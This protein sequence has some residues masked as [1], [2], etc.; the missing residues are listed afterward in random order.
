MAKEALAQTLETKAEPASTALPHTGNK[1]DTIREQ[2][3]KSAAPSAAD[4]QVGASWGEAHRLMA[5]YLSGKLSTG[6]L[7]F[8]LKAH[9]SVQ[10]DTWIK[11]G[12]HDTTKPIEFRDMPRA[13]MANPGSDL[14]PQSDQDQRQ[15]SAYSKDAK[16]QADR[17]DDEHKKQEIQKEQ[18]RLEQNEQ[19]QLAIIISTL[20]EQQAQEVKNSHNWREIQRQE[21]LKEEEQI[22]EEATPEEERQYL[23]KLTKR[24]SIADRIRLFVG[25]LLQKTTNSEHEGAKQADR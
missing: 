11:Q 24:L 16:S 21:K 9:N 17:T 12:K 6:Q 15:H 4:E 13:S 7:A 10:G 25:K 14:R 19:Q 1:L 8:R 3:G 20:F 23:T 5:L 18:K 2:V 22:I